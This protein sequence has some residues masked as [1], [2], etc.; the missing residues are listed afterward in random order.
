MDRLKKIYCFFFGHD[1][2]ERKVLKTI[3]KETSVLNSCILCKR[4]KKI[5]F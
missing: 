4:C 5:I 3:D 1:W 2:Q